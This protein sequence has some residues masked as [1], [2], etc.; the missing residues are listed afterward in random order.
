MTTT[1]GEI[2]TALDKAVIGELDFDTHCDIPIGPE[3]TCPNVGVW[4]MILGAHCGGP[5]EPD[6]LVMCQQHYEFVMDGAYVECGNCHGMNQPRDFI[7][8]VERLKP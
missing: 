5:S 4:L 1:A 3:E 6:R 7:V 8:T 2:A